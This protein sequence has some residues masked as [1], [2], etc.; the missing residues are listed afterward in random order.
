M[1]LFAEKKG[2][3]QREDEGIAR[4]RASLQQGGTMIEKIYP[5]SLLFSRV[6]LNFGEFIIA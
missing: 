2:S 4:T 1:L 3:D 5:A 6:H